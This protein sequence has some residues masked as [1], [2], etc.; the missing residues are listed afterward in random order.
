VLLIWTEATTESAAAEH[1]LCRASVLEKIAGRQAVWSRIACLNGAGR[2][3]GGELIDN[4]N[5]T[6]AKDS[7]VYENKKNARSKRGN[8][9]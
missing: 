4:L 1:I 3:A 5:A 8:Y 7:E 9:P 6:V 2:L